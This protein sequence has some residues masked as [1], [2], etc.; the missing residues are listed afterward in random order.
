LGKKH[1][2]NQVLKIFQD[3]GFELDEAAILG[4]DRLEM[5]GKRR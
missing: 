3:H 1:G 4:H 2:K 5:A